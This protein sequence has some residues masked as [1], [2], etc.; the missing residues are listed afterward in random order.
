[1]PDRLQLVIRTP[2]RVVFDDAVRS[3]RLPT[4]TGQVGVRPR[5]EPL[6]LAVEPGL[7]LISGADRLLFA[8]SAGGLFDGDRERA[9]LYTPFAVVG[10]RADEVADALNQLLAVPDSEL[11]VHRRLGELEDRIVS[12]LRHRPTASIGKVRHG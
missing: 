9:A 1:M 10:E 12:E 6:V 2:H 3:A 8:A 4:A 7:I 11:S 5:E